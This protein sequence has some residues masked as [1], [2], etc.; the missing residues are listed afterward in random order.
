M[1]LFDRKYKLMR[2]DAAL[3]RNKYNAV[4]K[5]EQYSTTES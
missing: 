3:Y 1:E 4:T 2:R 5:I